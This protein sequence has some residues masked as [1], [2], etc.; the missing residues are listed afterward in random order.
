MSYI[1]ATPG[2]AA[3]VTDQFS[4]NGSTTA[5]TMSVT[6]AGATS[7]IVAVSGVLQDPTTY[8]VAGT[9]LTFSAAPPTGTGN[10]SVRYLGLPAS[11]VTNTAY[12]TVTEF[13]ATAGQ[14]VFSIPSY[15]IGYLNVY[16]NGNRLGAA[17]YTATTGTSV[18]LATGATVGDLITTESFYISSLGTGIPNT[19]G[20]VSATNLDI[21]NT[22][23]TGSVAV[24]SGTTAQRPTGANG[25]LRYN[26]TTN[27]FEGYANGAWGAI[28][29][30]GGGA[31][32]WQAVQTAAFTAVAGNAYPVNTT[33]G[34]ITVTLPASPTAGSYIVVT[35]YA[36]T[37][38]TNTCTLAPNGNKIS[39]S[40]SNVILNTNGCSVNLVY[41][42]TTQ[43]WIAYS[44]LIT[45]PV[46]SYAATYLIVSGG[47]GGG[48]SIQTTTQGGGGG[49]GGVLTGATTL[50]SGTAYTIAVGAGGAGVS[51][52]NGT[53]G[54]ASSAFTL[55]SVGGGGGGSYVGGGP[56]VAGGS[57]GGGGTA[58]G[59][60]GAGTSGQG[61]AGG[62]ATAYASNASAAGGG[63]GGGGSVGA[64]GS[65]GTGGNGGIGLL[66][67][68][69]ST[70]YAGGGGAGG[71]N[72]AGTGGSGGGGNGVTGGYNGNN[73]GT[74]TGGGGGGG[75]S[76]TASPDDHAGGN[77]GSGVV[78]VAYVGAQ[79]GTGGA[80]STSGGYTLH[81]FTTSGTFTA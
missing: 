80:V 33:A 11:G 3:F 39:G 29:G 75:A 22:N 61:Y 25:Q 28:G 38:G 26:S 20:S 71:F 52:Q 24:P 44:G 79:R 36:R 6:P 72:T 32:S 69:N 5:F 56:G 30:G 78:V 34:A 42:D 62:T 54:T 76:T 55:S 31:G 8:A 65:G 1:G 16:Q 58:S 73:G 9:T 17:D 2:Y 41:L 45:S 21:G 53:N 59:T 81:T 27:S 57:G 10:I 43:G 46:A 64:N 48:G 51:R 49:G 74:N 60:G 23:G 47:G 35:D 40:T 12:R 7:L 37:F 19:G 4:G 77:G 68:P 66:F 13:T 18:T 70:Y 14:T 63:G 15:T 67:T 50:A